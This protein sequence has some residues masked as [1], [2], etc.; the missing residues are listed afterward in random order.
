MIKKRLLR[1]GLA[2]LAALVIV[3]PLFINEGVQADT[4]QPTSLTLHDISVY[5]SL[6]TDNDTLFIVP[7]SIPYGTTPVDTIDKT[8]IF[9]LMDGPNLIGSVKAYPFYDYGYGQGLISFYFPPD[10]GIVWNT[11][12]KIVITE[13][14]AFFLSPTSSSFTVGTGDYSTYS[15]NQTANRE[16]LQ[17]KVTSLAQEFTI[18]WGMAAT[19]LTEQGGDGIILSTYGAAYFRNAIY[20]LQSMCPALFLLQTTNL[21]YTTR[22]WDYSFA[23]A[24]QN[25]FLGTWVYSDIL[26]GFSGLWNVPTSTATSMIS[27]L[28][29]IVIFCI[30]VGLAQGSPQSVQGAFLDAT[31]ILIFSTLSGFFSAIL[32]AALAFFFVLVG[33]WI[34]L[35]NKA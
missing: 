25:T 26:A 16:L 18:A 4:A 7:Y 24:L 11:E 34:L 8:F 3:T 6:I 13:N 35:F 32:D 19:P 29:A 33:G 5:N 15:E 23:T 17:T 2:S 10:S 14:P 1:I 20:G 22:T 9:K 30:S 28:L 31:T 21:D 12:Y 27:F